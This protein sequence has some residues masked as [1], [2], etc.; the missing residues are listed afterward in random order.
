MQEGLF[1][2][3]KPRHQK[4][5]PKVVLMLVAENFNSCFFL[6]GYI[7]LDCCFRVFCGQNETYVNKF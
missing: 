3:Y 5:I 7:S 6:L 1:Q 4:K 2:R